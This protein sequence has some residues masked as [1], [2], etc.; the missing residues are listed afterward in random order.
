MTKGGRRA[1]KEKRIDTILK[2]Y[3]REYSDDSS[4]SELSNN[5]EK[6]KSKNHDIVCN[7]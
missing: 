6:E 1:N 5:E 2:C 4:E 3:N 7:F